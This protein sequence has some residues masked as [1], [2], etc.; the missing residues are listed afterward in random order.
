MKSLVPALAAAVLILPVLATDADARPAHRQ[1]VYKVCRHS[2]GTTGLVAG[3]V[4]GAVVGGKVI[5]GGV[6][7]PL[8]GAA[9]GALGGR[10]IDRSMT[11]KKRCRYYRR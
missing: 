1:R 6:A 10:A 7:G 8:V 9:A 2:S 3:G 5:G 4:A 11:A